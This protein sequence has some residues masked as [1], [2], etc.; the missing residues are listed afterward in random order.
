[1]NQQ[2]CLLYSQSQ[3]LAEMELLEWIIFLI[4]KHFVA[5]RVDGE[6]RGYFTGKCPSHSV[7]HRNHHS[8]VVLLKCEKIGWNCRVFVCGPRVCRAE[9]HHQKIILI[10]L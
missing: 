3:T 9:V 5:D 4:F 6:I 8:I 1:M 7:G 2:V 10:P